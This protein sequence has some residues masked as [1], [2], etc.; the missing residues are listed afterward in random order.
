MLATIRDQVQQ[1]VWN[2]LAPYA[3][4]I[5]ARRQSLIY[6]PHHAASTF[7]LLQA[8]QVGLHYLSTSGRTLTL[9]VVEPGQFFGHS[10]LMSGPTYDTFA[11]VIRNAR[12]LA[13]QR[14][15]LLE[16][17]SE[18]PDLGV[19]LLE[20]VGKYRLAVSRRLDEVAFKSVPAR[21]ASL[22][23]DMAGAISEGQPPQLPHRT[24]QQLADMINAYRETVTKVINQFRAA[25]LLDID[26]SGITLLNLSGLREL[27][28]SQ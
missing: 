26:R 24:H 14:D 6:T 27:A 9:Q 19:M 2:H 1:Q 21:L 28:Q 13:L 23:L 12:V 17:I 25:Q 11:E 20:I 5:T 4:T 8:G 15:Q 18:M 16:I 7:Y 3:T 22:L 10:S